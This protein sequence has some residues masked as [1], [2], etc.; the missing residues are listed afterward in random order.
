MATMFVTPASLSS[1]EPLAIDG[2][3]SMAPASKRLVHASRPPTRR[4]N[5]PPSG[6]TSISKDDLVSPRATVDKPK[7]IFW[8]ALR[9]FILV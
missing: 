1:S 9:G 3:T 2:C 4:R 7:A 6:K 8:N 5:P